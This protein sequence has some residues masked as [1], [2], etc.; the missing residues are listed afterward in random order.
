MRSASTRD[1]Y[2]VLGVSDTA[3]N[4]EIKIA[5]RSLARRYHPDVAENKLQAEE[6]FKEINAAYQVLSDSEK[7]SDYRSSRTSFLQ[8]IEHRQQP[9]QRSNNI[10]PERHAWDH[11]ETCRD[12][13]SDRPDYVEW[14]SS[15]ESNPVNRFHVQEDAADCEAAGS[16]GN[17]SDME[18]LLSL[19]EAAQGVVRDIWCYQT[20]SCGPCGGS[21]RE[22]WH[23][24]H[25]CDGRGNAVESA[26]YRVRIPAGVLPGRLLPLAEFGEKLGGNG[27][28]RD[29][30][31][32]IRWSRHPLF[33]VE[34]GALHCDVNLSFRQAALGAIVSI[35]TLT[36]RVEVRIPPCVRD[37][38]MLNLP[39][40][41]LPGLD[42]ERGDLYGVIRLPI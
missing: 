5:F 34:R 10:R 31:L 28:V 9:N 15:L 3:G 35:P 11:V 39:G 36:G 25:A 14:M 2:E 29:V 41:G 38:Q 37:G 30:H 18:I 22:D 21:G 42:G 8:G 17:E 19:E 4:T 33:R 13:Q 24:C 12:R 32:R 20:V 40:C 27:E 23:G 16:T 26:Q 6:R 7:R 1:Y